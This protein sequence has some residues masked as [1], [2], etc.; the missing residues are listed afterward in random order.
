LVTGW[1]FIPVDERP[2]FL[3]LQAHI[4]HTLLEPV[5]VV[6][7]IIGQP[8]TVHTIAL[9]KLSGSQHPLSFVFCDFRY[10]YRLNI[11]Q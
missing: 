8:F 6:I 10:L 4:M 2:L 11:I 1:K 9:R 3:S 5:L 7:E